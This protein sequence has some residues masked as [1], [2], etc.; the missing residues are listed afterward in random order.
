V[1]FDLD[2][3]EWVPFADPLQA[4]VWSATSASIS[5][6]WVDGQCV[7]RDGWIRTVD[8]RQIRAQSHEAAARILRQAGLDREGIPVTTQL[9]S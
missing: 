3:H 2:H 8:E 6:T 7:F 9:Y 5:Q 1:L 4:L